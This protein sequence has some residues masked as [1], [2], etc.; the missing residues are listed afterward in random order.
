M[1]QHLPAN[2]DIL[3][4]NLFDQ[5]N[6]TISSDKLLFPK[7]DKHVKVERGAL[8]ATQVK[9]VHNTHIEPQSWKWQKLYP[10]H[11]VPLQDGV[12]NLIGIFNRDGLEVGETLCSSG[13]MMLL[14]KN[15]STQRVFILQ[16]HMWDAFNLWNCIVAWL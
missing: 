4:M 11:A 10:V 8:N 3:G 13:Y 5:T 6:A 15:K 14:V 2:R 12:I 7:H 1:L 9:A 16:V